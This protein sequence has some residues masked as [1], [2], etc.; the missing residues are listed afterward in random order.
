[1]IDALDHLNLRTV[2]LAEMI[3]WYGRILLLEPGPRPDF[4]FP[5]AWLYAGDQALV[6][7]V[8]VASEPASGTDLKLE[9]GA[10]RARGLAALIARLEAA[11]EGFD[12]ARVPGLPVIQVNVRDPD[13]NH[14]HVDFALAEAEAA[15]LA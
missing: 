15:G 13:G 2:R 5:G 12:L 4:G 10:F 6:H 8:E 9:H 1:M 3:A 7:L 14:L 11:G